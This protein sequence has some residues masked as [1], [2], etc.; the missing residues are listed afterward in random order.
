M[1]RPRTPTNVLDARGAFDK[2]PNRKR[3]DPEVAGPLKGAPGYFDAEQVAIWKEVV[4]AAPK[5]V[6]TESDRFALEI[7]VLLLQQFRSDPIDFTAAKLVRLETLLGKFGMTP[8]DRAKVAGP[9]SKK[10]GGNA[11]ADL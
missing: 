4:K 6:V 2:N 9:V 10:P 5:N 8:S 1:A 3:E 11:F 7:A